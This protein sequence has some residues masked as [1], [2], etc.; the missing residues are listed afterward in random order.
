MC[1]GWLTV[2][3]KWYLGLK[4]AFSYFTLLPV[5]FGK[6][7]DLTAKPVLASMLFFLPFIGMVLGILAVGLYGLL[8]PL[9]WY[10]AVISALVYMM[11]Y[12]FLHTEAVIDVA[13]AL[14]ASHSGKDAYSIIK[15]PTVGAMG[16]LW[17]IGFVLLK[18]SG[19]VFLLMHHLFTP[20]IAVLMVSRLA[21]LVLFYTQTF[22]SSFATQL[23]VALTAK[24]FWSAFILFGVVGTLLISIHFI[25]L[26][27]FG[28]TLALLTTGFIKSKLG[29]VN[30]DVLGSTL[31]SVEILLLITVA[32]LW[33]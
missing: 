33:H 29:F 27:L 14:Y 32:L 30:G 26:L 11:L 12:G 25:F 4:F 28:V 10:G 5:S 18:V 17:A 9:G 2:F 23:K 7:V 15:E 3:F 6:E 20:L 16:V 13:D 1:R 24:Y 22:N 8:E 31:E 21:L 19:I